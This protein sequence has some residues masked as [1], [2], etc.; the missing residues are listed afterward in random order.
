[1]PGTKLE[2]SGRVQPQLKKSERRLNTL[3][4]PLGPLCLTLGKGKT[5]SCWECKGVKAGAL[6]SERLD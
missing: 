6:D 3:R 5:T 2:R 1:M 4:K